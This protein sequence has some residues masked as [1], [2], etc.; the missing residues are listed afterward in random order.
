[1]ELLNLPAR[2]ESRKTTI[3][4]GKDLVEMEV[5]ATTAT[6]LG[7]KTDVQVHG[8]ARVPGQPAPLQRALSPKLT[9]KVQEVPFLLRL[10]P[11]NLNLI[12]GREAALK[13]HAERKSYD[14]PIE[15]EFRNFPE[16]IAPPKATIRSHLR[17]EVVPL[18]VTYQVPTVARRDVQVVARTSGEIIYQAPPASLTLH[19]VAPIQLRL[20]PRSVK[21][22]QG[23]KT[24]FKVTLVRIG[25]EGPVTVE[26][27]KLPTGVTAKSFSFFNK[28]GD[29]EITAS[30]DAPLQA[31]SQVQMVAHGSPSL[32]N[33]RLAVVNFNLSVLKAG[34][35]PTGPFGLEPAP[36]ILRLSPGSKATLHVTAQRI[37]YKGP[38]ALEVRN[39]PANVSAGKVTL[40]AKQDTAEIEVTAEAN[41]IPGEKT[42]VQ[43]VG[44]G[45]PDVKVP[46]P[47]FTVSVQIRSFDLR[48]Q[49]GTLRIAA[50]STAR[51]KIL[52]ARRTYK[53]P[54]TLEL[55]D[56]PPGLH[57]S[58]ATLADGQKETE[59][60]VSAAESAEPVIKDALVVGSSDKEKLPFSFRVLLEPG[61]F[62]LKMEPKVVK[63]G[64]DSTTRVKIVARRIGY[65]GPITISIPRNKLPSAVTASQGTIAEGKNSC[66]I[67]VKA[68]AKATEGDTVDVFALGIVPGSGKQVQSPCVTLSVISIG[69]EPPFELKVQPGKLQLK[70][71]EKAKLKVTVVR[72]ETYEGPL[73]LELRTCPRASALPR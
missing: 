1:M 52:A 70:Q 5:S 14:G 9:L 35:L 73:I 4:E 44:T 56:L 10:E 26:F 53:G 69:Q 38:I 50:G 27:Q 62:D 6:P 32:G 22:A 55:Q 49:P 25:Y 21:V 68:A 65:E 58:K 8:S 41:A 61:L 37:D 31:D 60:E 59:I 51:L 19:V 7:E 46:S 33:Q 17:T 66:E 16:G 39:L 63:V 20:E 71:G 18:K 47:N 57:A 3:P 28:T 15:L 45:Q 29:A 11:A 48:T 13:V 30:A 72:Q 40:G 64:N 23:G 36:S 34:S 2:V 67:E 24:R 42:D 54:I 43:I 12:Q